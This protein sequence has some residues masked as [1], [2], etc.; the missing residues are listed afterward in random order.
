MKQKRKITAGELAAKLS[1]NPE[2]VARQKQADKE[3][4]AREAEWKRAERPLV[5]ELRAAGF[6]VNS[7]WD[8]VSTTDRYDDALPILFRHLEEAYPPR[9]REGIA[10]ALAVPESQFAIH[11][12]IRLYKVEDAFDAKSGLAVAISVA[13]DEA[14]LEQIFSLLEDDRNGETR[15]LLLG[16]LERSQDARARA[17]LMRLGT[18]PQLSKEI[19]IILRRLKRKTK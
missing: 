16:A 13:A 10:R 18:D 7:A 1:A 14:A 15:I 19:Q 2:F 12:L 11:D 5:E 9:V 4:A 8:F 3:L 6:D 17:T